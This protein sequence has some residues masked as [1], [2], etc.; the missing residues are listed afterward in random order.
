MPPMPINDGRLPTPRLAIADPGH[1]PD[2]PQ[3]T[4][5]IIAPIIVLCV[6]VLFLFLN[7][8]HNT[9]FLRIFGITLIVKAVT[10]ADP[11]RSNSSPKSFNCK[12]LR[13]ISCFAI[14]PN[15]KPKP[16]NIPPINTITCFIFKVIPPDF[17][18]KVQSIF[19][20]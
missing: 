11:P 12:K 2:N 13:T 19:Q 14:P 20:L 16:N 3:P 1:K 8:P 17:G 18:R 5:K 9:G 7:T 4:P 10:A 6:N 15:A